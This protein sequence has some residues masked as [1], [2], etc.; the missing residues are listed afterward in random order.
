MNKYII[1]KHTRNF[2][3]ISFIDSCKMDEN[4]NKFSKK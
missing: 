2:I 4:D 1:I 3:N